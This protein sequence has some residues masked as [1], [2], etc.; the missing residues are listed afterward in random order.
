MEQSEAKMPPSI[1]VVIITKNEEANIR[2]CIESIKWADE[3]V[4][5]DSGSTDGTL[6]I[7]REYGCRIIER[8]WEG[9]A[10]QKNFAIEQTTG[11]WVLSLDAD[12]EVTPE[13]ADEIRQAVESGGADAYDMPRL[14]RFLGK[15]MRHGGWYPDRQLRLLKRGMGAFKSVP[16]H[17]HIELQHGA[18]PG[19]LGEPLLHYTYPTIQD[20]VR[21]SDMYT[22]IEVQARVAANRIP[23]R[24][25]L[26][27]ITAF[28][29]KFAEV[30]LYKQ[31]WRDGL[32]GFVAAVMMAS[33]VHM[34]MAKL[35]AHTMKE[36]E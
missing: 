9:Y 13:L 14:N 30:Y 12:E 17:E 1:S 10:A 8:E 15:W 23:R 22:D 21:K 29:V 6:D 25:G 7:C 26:A 27:L 5:V 3:I 18:S 28:P 24:I 2:R 16:I 36:L 34:R 32:H 31:G 4:I 35:W 11:D 33:R 20:F 19:H